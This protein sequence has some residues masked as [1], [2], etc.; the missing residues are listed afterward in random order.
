MTSNTVPVYRHGRKFYVSTQEYE[1][2]CS[3]ERRQRR[4]AAQKSQNLPVPKSYQTRIRSPSVSVYYPIQRTHSNPSD[5]KYGVLRKPHVPINSIINT[6]NQRE[7]TQTSRPISRNYNDQDNLL[8][9]SRKKTP[10][11][12]R[13]NSSD[14]LID[15]QRTPLSSDNES[16]LKRSFS[17]EISQLV[18]LP[19]QQQQPKQQSQISI[20]RPIPTLISDY[21]MS[22]ITT[23]S[24]TSNDQS[25][26]QINPSNLTNYFARIK[27][28]SLNPPSKPLPSAISGTGSLLESGIQGSNHAY[29]ILGSTNSRIRTNSSSLLTSA[30]SDNSKNESYHQDT[31]SGSFSDDTSSSLSALIQRRNTDKN[32]SRQPEYVVETDD[33]YNQQRDLWT[34]STIRS[35]SSDGLTEKKRVRFADMEGLTLET[36]PNRNQLKSPVD[37]RVLTKQQHVKVS[38]DS[39]GQSRL[40]F[41]T[42]YPPTTNVGGSKLATDV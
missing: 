27:Q 42:F 24:M 37:N 15:N 8:V 31:T 32:R 9:I 25:H 30:I 18:S 4:T 13:S 5:Y 38:S 3:E 28:S 11:T 2:I 14:R 1:R 41:N 40:F 19:Q 6:Y 7:F 20:R 29:T 36:V 12:I 33:D 21:G 26:T 34:R 23:F 10:P 17:D 39:R 35:L 22:P 16:Q